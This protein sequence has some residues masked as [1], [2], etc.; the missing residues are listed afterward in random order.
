[1]VDRVHGHTTGLGLLALPAVAAGLADLDQLVL[2]VADLADGG[3]TVDHHATHLGGGHTQRGVVAFL[4]DQLDGD[5]GR[6]ADLAAL[7]GAQLDVVHGG[8]DRDETQRHGVAGLDVGAV[9]TLDRVT[10]VEAARSQDV[11]L[12]AVVVVEQ[13]DAA[14]AVRVVF[15][16]GDLGGHAILDPLEV[17]DAVLLLV[18]ATTMAGGL[19]A[20]AVAATG[21]GL[22][23]E[24]AL[25]RRGLGDLAEIGARLE[26]T[27]G[28]GGLAGTDSHDALSSRTAGFRPLP[29]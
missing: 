18:T 23:D 4:G 19:A 1:M 2:A 16:G 9:A 10:D 12:L 28:A 7:A 3:A 11:G 27:A 21:L 8:A 26:A 24:E 17:D 25:L 6:T 20:V 14:R 13:R 29:G 5:A 22:L 15:D